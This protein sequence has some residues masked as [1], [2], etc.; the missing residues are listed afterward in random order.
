MISVS[1]LLN[2]GTDKLL[3][4]DEYG[5]LGGNHISR[6]IG[7]YSFDIGSFFFQADSPLAMHFPEIMRYYIPAPY[8]IGRITPRGTVAPYPF[9]LKQDVLAAGPLEWVRIGLSLLRARIFENANANALAFT[10]YWLGRRFTEHSGLA[11]YM[12][13]FFGVS[14]SAIEATFAQKRMRWIRDNASLRRLYAVSSTKA[15]PPPMQY[16]R[17]REGFPHLYS[18]VATSIRERGGEIRLGETIKAIGRDEEGFRIE[19][20][21]GDTIRTKNVVSTM[22]IELITALCGMDPERGLTTVALIS[23]FYSFEGERGFSENVLYNFTS[24]ADWKRLTMHSDFYGQAQNRSYFSV[25]VVT[26]TAEPDFAAADRDFREHVQR[27][28][29]FRGDLGLEGSALT[30]NLY[31]IYTTGSGEAANRAIRKLKDFGILSFGKQG[32][33][34]Y[35]PTAW[36][37]GLVAEKELSAT[38][39]DKVQAPN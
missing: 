28:G 19:T 10:H 20:A 32:G 35:Q 11:N 24:D 1:I 31:P 39:R 30:K 22:P 3:L 29:L 38:S 5:E 12:R 18:A 21:G 17:P 8:T 4:L 9:S 27:C 15:P 26:R 13:R 2:Q 33:F 14:P 37:S 7:D 34:D 25:E 6:N 36:V 23:L 16:V